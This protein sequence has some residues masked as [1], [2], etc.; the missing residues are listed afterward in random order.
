MRDGT[1][2]LASADG[3]ALLVDDYRP[4]HRLRV[5]VRAAGPVAAA[6]AVVGAA[7]LWRWNV[8][9]GGAGAR[10]TALAVSTPSSLVLVVGAAVVGAW[11]RGR[12]DG[13]V[14]GG[15]VQRPDGSIVLDQLESL[16]PQHERLV[17]TAVAELEAALGDTAVKP[18]FPSRNQ[19]ELLGR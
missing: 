9:V 19:K 12:A 18:R 11:G 1:L 16:S 6:V 8:V 5:A 4:R 3:L 13:R 10:R 2:A 7:V 14:V 15:W 17:G